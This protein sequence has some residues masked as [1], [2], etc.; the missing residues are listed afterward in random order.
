MGT[1]YKLQQVLREST[2]S[3]TKFLR[4]DETWAAGAGGVTAHSALTGLTTGDDHTQYVINTPATAARNRILAPP[5]AR[6]FI[7]DPASAGWTVDHA[8][9][10]VGSIF[11][12]WASSGGAPI[13]VQIDSQPL[14][15]E[16]ADLQFFD[17][18]Y[19]LSL[20]TPT[21]LAGNVSLEMPDA[22]GTPNQVLAT[23]GSGKLSFATVS[24]SGLTSPQVLARTL[25]A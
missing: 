19:S 17:G 11:R 2:K 4:D 7:C 9:F 8:F 23:N 15:L 16:N 22:D 25:G 14:Q 5:D 20:T 24:G 1:Y 13:R 18:T 10:E 3:G 12:V 21:G 6:G